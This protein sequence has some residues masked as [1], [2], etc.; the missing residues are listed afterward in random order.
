MQ[1]YF[2][3]K[4]PQT[5]N[6]NFGKFEKI[7]REILEKFEKIL[8]EILE[9]L[10]KIHREILEKNKQTNKNIFFLPFKSFNFFLF[11]S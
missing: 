5:Q 9:N 4:E 10:K 11:Q 3:H 2:W 8:R 6:R 1:K 7:L